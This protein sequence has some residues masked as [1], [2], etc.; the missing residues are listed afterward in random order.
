MKVSEFIEWLK[1]QP[2]DATVYVQVR[3]CGRY[4]DDYWESWYSEQ[5]NPSNS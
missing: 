1:T 5:F 4:G 3:D 2:Q